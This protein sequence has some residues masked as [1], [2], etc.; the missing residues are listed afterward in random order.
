MK[1][2]LLFTFIV[3]TQATHLRRDAS[4]FRIQPQEAKI[5]RH[6]GTPDECIIC[7]NVVAVMQ[8]SVTEDGSLYQESKFEVFKT[9]ARRACHGYS[10]ATTEKEC[11]AIVDDPQIMMNHLYDKYPS[12]CEV[13]GHCMRCRPCPPPAECLICE[14]PMAH[15]LGIMDMVHT[16]WHS[17]KEWM[18]TP[19][20]VSAFTNDP[21]DV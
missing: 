10:G 11:L 19:V 15:D 13:M 5:K 7:Q 14:P 12:T 3:F 9:V 6:V 1:L 20:G 4:L 21:F 2:L 16:S 8:N 17:L 18:N